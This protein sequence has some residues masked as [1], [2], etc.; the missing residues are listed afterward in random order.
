MIDQATS[1]ERFHRHPFGERAHYGAAAVSCTAAQVCRTSMETYPLR[2]TAHALA[3]SFALRPIPPASRP[4]PRA[5]ERPL[6]VQCGGGTAPKT[7]RALGAGPQC[8]H[9]P[10]GPAAHSLAISCALQA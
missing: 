7:P 4:P 2:L 5:Q 1:E 10:P 3:T 8:S 6:A 9:W